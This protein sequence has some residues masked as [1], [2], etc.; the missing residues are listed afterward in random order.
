MNGKK[1]KIIKRGLPE[2]HNES[3]TSVVLTCSNCNCEYEFD[4]NKDSTVVS[5][6]H[7]MRAVVCPWCGEFH[8]FHW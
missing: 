2:L 5:H 6:L 3:E 8:L 4:I 7:F 1:M